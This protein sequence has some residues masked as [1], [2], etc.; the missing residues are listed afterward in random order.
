MA[1]IFIPPGLLSE[2]DEYALQRAV[3]EAVSI[4]KRNGWISLS[5]F[6]EIIRRACS[7]IWNLIEDLV[8]IWYAI[9]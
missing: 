1:Q 9:T 5:R 7:W 2:S 3:D 6:R 8:S 4:K